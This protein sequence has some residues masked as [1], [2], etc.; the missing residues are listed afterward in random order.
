MCST[1]KQKIAA[2]L[3][4]MMMERAF[5]KITVQNLMFATGMKRQSFYYH[6]QDTRDVLRWICR[7]ELIE[8]LESS[9]LEFSQWMLFALGLLDRDRSFYRRLF[10]AG[11]A[12]MLEELGQRAVFPR[13]AALLYG[14]KDPKAL[15]DHQRFTVEFSTRAVTCHAVEFV[16][17][18]RP[19]D[20]GMA[21]GHVQCLMETFHMEDCPARRE[22][23]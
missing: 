7:K 12:E 10:A 5:Q 9:K 3:R 16:N 2:T 17:S 18:R 11:G 22:G 21:Q 20:K 1:T 13:M 19:L 8:P 15:D 14:Q 4:Q 23:A 6:F